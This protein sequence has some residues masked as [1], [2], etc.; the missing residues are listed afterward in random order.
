MPTPDSQTL[1]ADGIEQNPWEPALKRRI[2]TIQDG[3]LTL[4]W[5]PDSTDSLAS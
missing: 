2:G 4:D 5:G 3:A 1:R